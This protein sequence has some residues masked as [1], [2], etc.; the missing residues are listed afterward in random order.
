MSDKALSRLALGLC[1]F[2]ISMT[3]AAIF[4]SYLGRSADLPPDFARWPEN[5]FYLAAPAPFVLVGGL[6]VVRQ[7]RNVYGW[8]MLANGIGQGSIQGFWVNYGIYAF[9]VAPKPL[10]LA[11]WAFW[12]IPIGW[13]LW[14]ITVPLL[15][16]LYPS[17]NLPSP[18]WKPIIWILAVVFTITP[19][20]GRLGNSSVGW[21]A[22]ANPSALTGSAGQVVESLTILVVIIVFLVFIASVISLISRA[23]RSIGVERLQ[24]KWFAYAASLVVFEL[25]IDFFWEPPQPWEALKETIPLILLPIAI[26]IAVLRYRLWDIDIIIRRTLVYGALTLTLGFV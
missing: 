18:R 16:L 9:L 7:P 10:P 6:I 21:I 8:L 17:N 23:W 24:Y 26:G 13:M 3:L 25:F 11:S 5:L 1:I 4:F 22:V 14:L 20:I 12:V 19:I 2:A 15:L